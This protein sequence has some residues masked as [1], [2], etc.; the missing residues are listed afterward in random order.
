MAKTFAEAEAEC[1][2][3]LEADRLARLP[4]AEVIE[5]RW[6]LDQAEPWKQL[7]VAKQD[8]ARQEERQCEVDRAVD[9]EMQAWKRRCQ[10]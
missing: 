3:Q 10:G 4:K 8:R 1:L 6:K 7:L 5:F 9:A 2:A